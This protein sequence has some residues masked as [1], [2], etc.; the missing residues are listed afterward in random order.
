VPRDNFPARLHRDEAV[1]NAREARVYRRG[2]RGDDKAT[3]H[4]EHLSVQATTPAEGRA[5][6]KAFLGVLEERKLLHK[7]RTA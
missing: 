1:L 6:G 7:A 5:A 3:V 2:H 4:I